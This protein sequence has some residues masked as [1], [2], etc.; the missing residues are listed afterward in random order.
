MSDKPDPR[1]YYDEAYAQL[2]VDFFHE[3]LTFGAGEVKGQP[4]RLMPFAEK[5][6]RDLHGW[7]W[8]DG[9]RRFKTVYL[10]VPRGNAK[11]QN[12]SA[13]AIDATFNDHI[14]IPG[15]DIDDFERN[16]DPRVIIAAASEQQARDILFESSRA[17]V[18]Q[19]P[20]LSAA[21]TPYMK[22]ILRNRGG[23][24]QVLAAD[25]RNQ[26]GYS[27]SLIV[28]D[29]LHAHQT[30]RLFE[31]LET[32]L[33]KRRG[34]TM[35]ILTTA[36]ED[37]ES[38]RACSRTHRYAKKVM[39]GEIDDP[40]FLPVIFEEPDYQCQIDDPE[41]IA[42]ANP[43]L[44]VTIQL[45]D[46]MSSAQKAKHSPVSTASFRRLH[47][48]QTVGGARTWIPTTVVQQN[49]HPVDVKQHE[50]T[51]CYAGLDL[52]SKIDLCSLCLLFDD[53][54]LIW[55]HWCPKSGI[56]SRS[57]QDSVPY[58]TWAAE[59]HIIAC[60]DAKIDYD[61]IYDEVLDL[62][63]R[64][65]IREIG[66]DP[67][68]AGMLVGKLIDSGLRMIEV[69]QNVMRMSEPYKEL[70]ARMI[71]SQYR[72]DDKLMPWQFGN[73]IIKTDPSGSIMLAKGR[74]PDKVD[75]VAALGIA[76]HCRLND[77]QRTLQAI[78]FKTTDRIMPASRFFE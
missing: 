6:V 61:S 24:L 21:G 16:P 54:T 17:M 42:R 2:H 27:P 66:Y 70:E 9:T 37:L 38:P 28:V 62:S 45:D 55:R 5:L 69:P 71:A 49:I 43:G 64:F 30:D 52:A 44:G 7:R 33:P 34:C 19:S 48:N 68:E 31:A 56:A 73:A 13:I 53:G 65:H 29:E 36:P 57:A 74:C 76:E 22:S 75:G 39:S 3:L 58:T 67:K 41:C 4:F 47:L 18:E 10:A 46:L 51:P 35:V 23:S 63:E 72:F 78:E 32:A 20:T 60:G 15:A 8:A 59:G 14:V 25:G 1:F 40:R 50:K 11:S 12:G 77:P 26:H